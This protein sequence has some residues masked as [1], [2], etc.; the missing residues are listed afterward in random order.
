MLCRMGGPAPKIKGTPTQVPLSIQ[1]GQI[2]HVPGLANQDE[3]AQE[4]GFNGYLTILIGI[5]FA[6]HR[7][8]LAGRAA[9]PQAQ[10]IVVEPG[11]I[12]RVVAQGDGDRP[13]EA[14]QLAKLVGS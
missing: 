8:G 3:L 2:E 5:L 13:V 10:V 11:E 1:T 12:R 14:L 9:L 7:P 6:K 4:V